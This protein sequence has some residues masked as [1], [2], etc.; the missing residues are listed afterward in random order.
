MLSI[1]QNHFYDNYTM[2]MKPPGKQD[3]QILNTIRTMTKIHTTT[4][5]EDEKEYEAQARDK[6]VAYLTLYGG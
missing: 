1:T 3:N 6:N 4:I 2:T 5:D